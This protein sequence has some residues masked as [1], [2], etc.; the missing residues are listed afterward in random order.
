M[1][2]VKIAI[3]K[4]NKVPVKPSRTL[5]DIYHDQFINI[6]ETFLRGIYNDRQRNLTSKSRRKTTCRVLDKGYGIL[7]TCITL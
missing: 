7:Q 5:K 4:L 6:N 1:D 3:D 2:I